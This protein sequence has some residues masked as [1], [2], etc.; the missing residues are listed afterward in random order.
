MR[1]HR[2]I[3]QHV[4]SVRYARLL[5]I[6]PGATP[7]EVRK[8]YR[9]MARRFHPD[10]NPRNRKLAEDRFKQINEAYAYFIKREEDGAVVAEK[11][12]NTNPNISVTGWLFPEDVGRNFFTHFDRFFAGLRAQ[13][14]TVK[15][16]HKKHNT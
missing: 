11:P 14:R 10:L 2:D 6:A 1:N 3:Q 15:L 4:K 7:E 9:S 13:G 12:A 16:R 8:A 5:N